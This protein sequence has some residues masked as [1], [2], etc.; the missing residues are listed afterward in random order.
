[1]IEDNAKQKIEKTGEINKKLM[2]DIERLRDNLTKSVVGKEEA[3]N[4]Y[5]ESL[6]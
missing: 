4:C 1:M 3:E 5:V 6:K 2:M